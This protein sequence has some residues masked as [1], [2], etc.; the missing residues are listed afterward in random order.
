M[1]WNLPSNPVDLEQREGRVHRFKGHAVRRNI[2]ATLG[3][4]LVEEGFAPGTDPWDELFTRAAA[5]RGAEDD[6]MVPFWVFHEGPATVERHVPLLP[7]SRDATSLPR[8]RRTLAAYRLAFGQPRQE[9]FI[10]FLNAERSDAELMEIISKVRIDLTPPHLQ[11]MNHAWKEDA[12]DDAVQPSG[13]GSH[14][15]RVHAWKDRTLERAMLTEGFVSIGGDELGDLSRIRRPEV[16]HA[17]LTASMPDKRPMAI[18]LYVG[19]WR[20]FLWNAQVGDV[21]V[22][23]TRDR[24]VAIGE[25]SGPYTYIADGDERARHRRPVLWK[26]VGIERSSLGEDLLRTMNSQHTVQDF[27]AANATARL[28]ALAETRIDPGR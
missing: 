10:E 21:V 3:P 23:G 28:R 25:F 20:R 11:L 17:L 26:G 27:T 14:A 15:Y 7:F 5:T 4:V 18:T 8:L 13:T 9:E 19:Y 6:E 22:L 24:K 2:A 1:H 12:E 16:I